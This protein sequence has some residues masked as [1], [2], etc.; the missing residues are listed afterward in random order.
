MLSTW[1]RF[2]NFKDL[3]RRIASDTVLR[4]EAFNIAKNPTFNGYQRGIFAQIYRFFDKKSAA[5]CAEKSTTHNRTGTN[6]ENQ[7]LAKELYKPTIRSFKKHKVYSSFKDIVWGAD[8]LDKQL[9]SEFSN[10]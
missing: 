6:F 10:K 2:A 7:Q 4:G 9:I 8:I 5:T 1:Y 3:L